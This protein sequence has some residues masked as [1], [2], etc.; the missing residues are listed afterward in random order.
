MPCILEINFVTYDA[1]L[2]QPQSLN[3]GD[4]LVDRKMLDRIVEDIYGINL[5]FTVMSFDFII[6]SNIVSQ[7]LF[8]RNLRSCLGVSQN[9]S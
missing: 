6:L 7:V 3:D 1:D 4:M 5:W 2:L 9:L 8:S